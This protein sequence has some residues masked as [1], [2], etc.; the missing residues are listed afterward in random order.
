MARGQEAG[1]SLKWI[2][3]LLVAQVLLLGLYTVLLLVPRVPVPVAIRDGL[4]GNLVFVLPAVVML[5]RGW[6]VRSDRAWAWCLAAAVLSFLA[7]NLIYVFWVATL[8]VAPYPSWA[9]AGYLSLFPFTVAAVLLSMRERMG[10]LRG[11]VLLDGLAG[12][13][14]AATAAALTVLPL[15]RTFEGGLIQVVVATAYPVG[16]VVVIAMVMGVVATTGGRPGSFYTYLAAGLTIFALADVLYGYRVA[17]GTYVIG[18]PLDALWALGVTLMAHGLWRPRAAPEDARVGLSSLWVIAISG[19]VATGVLVIG[20]RV[21]LPPV[22]IGL[23]VATLLASAARTVVTFARVRDMAVIQQQA[24]TDD[25]TGVAN[26]RSLYAHI[27]RSLEG[28][29]SDRVVG[30]ALLDLDRFKEVNDS[31]GHQAGD[32]LLQA[33]SARLTSALASLDARMVLARLGGDEF[34]ILVPDADDADAVVTVVDLVCAALR[35]PVSLE[36]LMSVHVQASTGVAVA[37]MHAET[38]SD[39]LRCADTAMYVAKRARAGVQLYRP[40]MSNGTQERLQL[41]EDLHRAIR[42]GELIV[43]YQPKVD[44]HG[45]VRG[46]EA[47]VRWERPGHGLMMPESFLAVAED[48]LLMPALTRIV[49]DIALRDCAGLRSTGLDLSVSVNL[50][51]GDLLDGGLPDVVRESLTKHGLPP[52]ALTLEITETNVMSDPFA[53]QLTL[54]RLRALGVEL[55]IDDYG[56]GHC[57]LAYLSRLPVQ[58]LKLDRSFVKEM[59]FDAKDAAIVRSSVDLAHS[60]GMRMVAEGVEDAVAAELLMTAG[61]DLAQGWHFAHPMPFPDLLAWLERGTDRH[62]PRLS[63]V[64]P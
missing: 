6:F 41:A 64:W 36:G 7:G 62:S 10:R 53:A 34:A 61:C 29:G 8:E 31:L 55:S 27:E 13:L 45:N 14:A 24:M 26:R 49:L 52:A 35:E 23:A 9:D 40:E 32:Q 22:L 38:R 39:V 15:A 51:T 20:S 12:G 57:S 21:D 25:L 33:V 5:A 44:L 43:H 56:T 18:T 42:L 17:N 58:E 3:S 30:L 59:A 2:R 4:I 11:S 48:H 50:S 1:A 46:I 16:D 60:L 28:R 63:P 19:L 37:P 47:L 54:E